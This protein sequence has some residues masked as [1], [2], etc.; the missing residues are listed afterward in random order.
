[1]ETSPPRIE[2][3]VFRLV[4]DWFPPGFRLVSDWFQTGSLKTPA[5]GGSL[6]PR[7]YSAG[8]G[9]ADIFAGYGSVGRERVEGLS[10]TTGMGATEAHSFFFSRRRLP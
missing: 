3:I 10:R 8:G 2:P 1:M 5:L 4:S 9:G 6:G 7:R